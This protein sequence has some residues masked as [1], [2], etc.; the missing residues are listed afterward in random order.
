MRSPIEI[1]LMIEALCHC[2]NVR[3][4]FEKLPATLTSCNC[5]ICNRLGALW[6][7][8]APEKVVISTKS[9]PTSTY[10]WGDGN[11]EFHHCAICGCATYYVTTEKS[12]NKRV[13]INARM[14]EPKLVNSIP[15]R[16]FDGAVS[17]KYVDD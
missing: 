5:S 10:L 12:T 14:I 13:A 15:V 16:K 8:V 2:G 4:E 6:A 1:D 17:W 3:L 11:L 9:E 7:Y